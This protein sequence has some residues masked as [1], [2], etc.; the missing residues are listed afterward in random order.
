M[1]FESGICLLFGYPLG[2]NPFI[3]GAAGTR[4]F[5]SKIASEGMY[6]IIFKLNFFFFCM[7]L[8]RSFLL[9]SITWNCIDYGYFMGIGY[10][11]NPNWGEIARD[12]QFV[13][14]MYQQRCINMLKNIMQQRKRQSSYISKICSKHEIYEEFFE[15]KT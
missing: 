8:Y 12:N 5:I 15:I 3:R 2:C 4:Y 13:I 7:Y 14:E 10:S 9:V 6:H 1:T 11:Y